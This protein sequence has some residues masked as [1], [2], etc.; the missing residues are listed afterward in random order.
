MKRMLV[1]S[2]VALLGLTMVV[3]TADAARYR[4]LR[5]SYSHQSCN[6]CQAQPGW[7]SPQFDPNNPNMNAPPPAPNA[8]N[9]QAF[10]NQQGPQ[11]NTTFYRGAPNAP[12]AGMTPSN[13]RSNADIQGRT[14]VQAGSQLQGGAKANATTD[15]NQ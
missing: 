14:N 3:D 7:Q 10:N 15:Q 1:C 12:Q 8:P 13:Q 5:R 11:G 2:V 4:R 6:A 9:G